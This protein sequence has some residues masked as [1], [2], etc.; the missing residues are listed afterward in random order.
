MSVFQLQAWT[1]HIVF[2]CKHVNG[3]TYQYLSLPWDALY[4]ITMSYE[5]S[6]VVCMSSSTTDIAVCYGAYVWIF[7]DEV[8]SDVCW[9]TL[10]TVPVSQLF[11]EGVSELS[12]LF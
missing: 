3:I 10:E 4:Y 11:E 5:R 12:W 2:P 8:F 9:E 1:I 7:M 6:C